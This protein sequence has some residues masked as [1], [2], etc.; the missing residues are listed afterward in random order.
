MSSSKAAGKAPVQYVKRSDGFYTRVPDDGNTYYLGTDGHYHV[1]IRLTG[2]AAS[3]MSQEVRDQFQ[4]Y[5]MQHNNTFAN[6]Q[7]QP[8]EFERAIATYVYILSLESRHE[9]LLKSCT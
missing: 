5:M 1:V 9:L 4:N 6:R 7:R 8:V 3:R 2:I